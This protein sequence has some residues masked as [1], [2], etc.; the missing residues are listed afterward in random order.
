M[1]AKAR[2]YDQM[3]KIK[4]LCGSGPF[5]KPAERFMLEQC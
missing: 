3:I 1:L 4:R 2:H 5:T